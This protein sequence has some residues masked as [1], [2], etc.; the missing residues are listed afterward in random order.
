[1]NSMDERLLNRDVEGAATAHQRLLADL[2]EAVSAGVDLAPTRPTALEGW[3]VG[4]LLTHIARHADS[5]VRMLDGLS[6]YEGGAQGRTE[7]IEAGADRDLDALVTDVRMSIW[8]LETRW[9]AHEDWEAS[10]TVV[11]GAVV[12]C[13]ELPF[14]RWREVAIHHV[15]LGIGYRFEDLDRE[16]LRRELRLMEML[17]K[18][19]QPMG[20]TGLPQQALE[21]DPPI[22]LAWLMGRTEVPGL[23][24]AS[25]F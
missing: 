13:H 11:S 25:I 12:A 9:A 22:R 23:A 2:D 15:D 18:A 24:P 5:V 1:M 21:L 3:S 8:R 7:Q 16:Y 10:A 14:R 4:H 6:Q 19:R 20:L 17:W